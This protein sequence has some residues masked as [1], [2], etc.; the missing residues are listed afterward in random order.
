MKIK[1]DRPTLC[2][3][4][5]TDGVQVSMAFGYLDG[6]PTAALFH[7]ETLIMIPVGVLATAISSGWEDDYTVLCAA[8]KDDSECPHC[9]MEGGA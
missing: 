8:L 9:E 7:E 1:T 4:N 2:F 5:R 3:S 6:E